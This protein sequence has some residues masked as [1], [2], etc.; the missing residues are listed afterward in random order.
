M[1][2]TAR[3]LSF[4]TQRVGAFE[5]GQVLRDGLAHVERGVSPGGRGEVKEQDFYALV[6]DCLSIRA[7]TL[8]QLGVVTD[9]RFR[10]SS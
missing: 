4:G 7:I 2:I 8:A 10:F 5:F 1:P 9:D 6:S 3:G